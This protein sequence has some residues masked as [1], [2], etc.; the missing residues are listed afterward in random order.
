M[1]RAGDRLHVTG[2]GE[3]TAVPCDPEVDP[4]W[5]TDPEM[6][7]QQAVQIADLGGFG[8]DPWRH[9]SAGYAGSGARWV[10]PERSGQ[11]GERWWL[12][13]YRFRMPQASD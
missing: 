3:W 4:R 6:G 7:A 13:R 11:S 12:L 9:V 5:L 1:L 2:R 8:V 10:W